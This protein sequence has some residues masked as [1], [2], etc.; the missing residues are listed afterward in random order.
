MG[1]ARKWRTSLLPIFC[2]PELSQRLYLTAREARNIVN[3]VLKRKEKLQV[4]SSS[5]KPHTLSDFIIASP[6][7]YL[8]GVFPYGGF[9][10]ICISIE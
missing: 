2:C 7:H 9:H 3:W 5:D 8:N 4:N 1:Q 6:L 10:R